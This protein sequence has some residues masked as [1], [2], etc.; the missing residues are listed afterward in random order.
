[1]HSA[2]GLLESIF[3]S[4][5]SKVSRASLA[6]VVK[7]LGD[8][9]LEVVAGDVAPHKQVS[10]IV[11]LDPLHN[12]TFPPSAVVLGIGVHET[13]EIC[14]VLA[15]LGEL[16]AA[17]LIV[18]SPVDQSDAR[19]L[20]A[21]RESG[22]V[23]IALTEAAD[24]LQLADVLR[25][26]VAQDDVGDEMTSTLGGVP[27]GDLFALA[28]AIAALIDAP[29]TIEDRSYRVLA[30]SGRQSEADAARVQTILERQVPEVYIREDE[31]RGVF[32]ALYKTEGPL[33]VEASKVSDNEVPRVAIAVRAGDEILGSI[34]AAVRS[35]LSV[36]RSDALV[37]AAKLVALHLLRRRA[38]ADVDHRLRA[39][40]VAT[41]LEGG[42]ESAHAVG[43]LGL[44]GKSV[45]VVAMAILD[46]G[47]EHADLSRLA[48]AR[49]RMTDAFAMHLSAVVPRSATAL[50]GDVTYGLIPLTGDPVRSEERVKRIATDFLSRT[51]SRVP[52]VVGIGSA[53]NNPR[54]LDESR[55]QADRAL[56]VLRT[57]AEPGRVAS[58]AEVHIDALVLELHDLSVARHDPITGPLSLILD[59]DERRGGSLLETLNYW[60]DAFGD[61]HAAAAAAGV[62]HNTFRYRLKRLREIGGINLDNPDERFAMMLQMRLMQ[63]GGD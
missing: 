58:M 60:L 32:Q 42:P 61:V 6:R 1:M 20:R 8:P 31:G 21:A 45:N 7:D 46:D 4:D 55:T 2:L 19:L 57:R 3:M 47:T 54:N 14:Q 36:E 9:F 52:A 10:A 53:V 27:A 25:T 39:D 35:P 48:S 26:V 16:N 50:L 13:T 62:H 28:N 18:R 40:L 38:G 49:Q 24:W 30:F 43:R 17:A 5:S 44:L 41:A 56:R 15:S 63:S 59:Y 51:G 12:S 37:D 33:Y 34:W 29:I 22:V 11:V 23:L